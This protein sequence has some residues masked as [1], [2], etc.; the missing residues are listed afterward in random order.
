GVYKL[1]VGPMN[2]GIEGRIRSRPAPLQYSRRKE[3]QSS[4]TELRHRLFLLEEVLDNF[5]KMGVVAD[6]LRCSSARDNNSDKVGG[7]H[8]RKRDVRVPAVAGLLGVG[9]V[10]RLEIVNDEM[11]LLLAGRGDLHF[12]AFLLQPLV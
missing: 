11:Q 2:V 6:V 8:V 4:M 1:R 9:V 10:A 3:R 7:M 12:V 5:A